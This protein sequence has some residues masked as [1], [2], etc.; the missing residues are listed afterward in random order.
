MLRTAFR[1][2]LEQRPFAID[3]I[4]ILP[5]H[6]HAIFTLPQ[7]DADFALRWRRIKTVFT[8]AMIAG[9]AS[10][11]PRDGGGRTAWQRRFWEHTILDA[12]DFARHV[13]Y[14]HHNPC[15][16]GQVAGPLD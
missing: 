8:R 16:H 9:G 13:D 4:V 12:T 7:G 14:I 2:V 10:F 3:A 11:T 15:K 6:L 5:D 1:T